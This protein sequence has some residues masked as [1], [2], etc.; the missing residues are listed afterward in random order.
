MHLA[1]LPLV[2]GV[3]VVAV[4]AAAALVACSRA[5]QTGSPPVQTQPLSPY[6]AQRLI[7]TPTSRVR[8]DSMGWVQ[9][10]GGARVAGRQL[11]SIIAADFSNRAIGGEWIMP[12]ELV[13][14]YDRNRSYAADPYNLATDPLRPATFVALSRYAEPLSSQLRTMIALHADARF[15]LVPVELRFA[16]EQL[17]STVAILRA[18]VLDARIAEAR[19]VAEVRSDPTTDPGKALVSVASRLA[20]Q[21]IAP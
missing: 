12:P 19:W 17:G 15:V 13:R 10:L 3:A 6:L 11:D 8:V 9:R 1:P 20:D 16:R 7:V 2:R 5:A 18:V 4:V 14:A 21:F